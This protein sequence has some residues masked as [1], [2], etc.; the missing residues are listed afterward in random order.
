MCRALFP[1][2]QAAVGCRPGG[3]KAL[4]AWASVLF[5]A[6]WY[7]SE[8]GQ[9]EVAKDIRTV[10]LEAKEVTLEAGYPNTL[11]GMNGVTLVIS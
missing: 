6:A 4:E 11:N 8:M 3:V 7:A 10:T 5:K 1:H 2:A 9:Y